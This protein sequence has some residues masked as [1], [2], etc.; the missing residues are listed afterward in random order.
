MINS[1]EL[2]TEIEIKYCKDRDEAQIKYNSKLIA[3]T[4]EL[5]FR[6]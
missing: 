6:S 1:N 5:Q 3:D 2:E 4:R